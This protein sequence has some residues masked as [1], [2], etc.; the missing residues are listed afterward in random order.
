MVTLGST[1]TGR[2]GL[3][4]EDRAWNIANSSVVNWESGDFELEGTISNDG[5]FNAN[6]DNAILFTTDDADEPL[7][8]NTGIFNKTTGDVDGA[9]EFGEGSPA[10]TV[11]ILFEN[12]GTVNVQ[13][14]NI[15]FYQEEDSSDPG[16]FLQT[17]GVTNLVGGSIRTF[18]TDTDDTEPGT[19]QFEGRELNGG[20]SEGIATG[21]ELIGNVSLTNT[22]VN[23]GQSPG[24]M[25]IVGNLTTNAGTIFNIEIASTASGGFDQINV[26]GTADFNNP[27][28]NVMFLGYVPPV[29]LTDNFSVIFASSFLDPPV[30]TI[31][32]PA[33]PPPR[34]H[35]NSWS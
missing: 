30:V 8:E 20:I 25:N 14:G 16:G 34:N 10:D 9:T 5:T 23:P 29:G 12:S 3:I 6:S 21:G 19:F 15:T 35:C 17:A 4:S 24:V 33:L 32:H 26:S 28:L 2:L 1:S 7:F 31:V 18:L 27:T 22:T 11:G 13:Q